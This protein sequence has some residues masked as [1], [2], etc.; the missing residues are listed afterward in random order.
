MPPSFERCENP[1]KPIQERAGWH[2]LVELSTIDKETDKEYTRLM[3]SLRCQS[4]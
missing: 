4:N 1:L 2:N 3:G